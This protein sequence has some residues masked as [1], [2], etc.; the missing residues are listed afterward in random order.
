MFDLKF[1]VKHIDW[2]WQCFHVYAL[3]AVSVT[4]VWWIRTLK[5]DVWFEVLS[6]AH[7]LIVAMLSCVWLTRKCWPGCYDDCYGMKKNWRSILWKAWVV[8]MCVCMALAIFMWKWQKISELCALNISS[9]VGQLLPW[10]VSREVMEQ[11]EEQGTSF[12]LLVCFR[13]VL[14]WREVL[15]GG[16]TWLPSVPGLQTHHWK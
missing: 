11:T 9:Q 7:W 14:W 16:S 3:I 15:F 8:F 13:K 5:R 1:W 6:E 12:V 2:L 4:I 10:W